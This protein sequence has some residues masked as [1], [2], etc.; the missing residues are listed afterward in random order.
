MRRPTRLL[1]PLA[2]A[3]GALGLVACEPTDLPT[4]DRPDD[5]VVLTGAEV[6]DLVGIA[7]DRLVAFKFVL[8]RWG[9]VPVQV[10]ER[11]ALDFAAPRN[12]AP[13]GRTTLFYTD[14]DTWTG[15]D[16]D[17][18]LDANDEV[19]FMARDAW[20]RARSFDEN[21]Y[22]YDLAEPP[23]VV[24][25]R[26]MEIRIHDPLA[27]GSASF[28]YL[29]ESAGGLDPTA[30]QSYVDYDFNL[31]SGDYTTTY[32]V[33][34][35]PN[36][37][38]S[39]VTTPAYSM[40]FA[41]R[42]I[43]DELRV[44]AGGASGVDVLDRHKS[45]FAGS[46][47][48]TETTFSQ[49]SG[50]IIASRSGPV[51]AVRSYLGANSGPVT[52]RD[53][54]LYSTRADTVTSLRVHAIPPLRDWFDYSAA[55][56]GMT[57]STNLDPGVTVDGQPESTATALV[58]WQM[59]SGPQ[60]SIVHTSEVD[61]NIAFGAGANQTFYRDDLTPPETQCTGDAVEYG[62]SGW[63]LSESIPCTDPL[64]NCTSFLTSTRRTTF[65]GPGATAA[66]AAKIAARDAAPLVATAA[67][68]TP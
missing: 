8:G 5:P 63:T 20:G 11:A 17:P 23:G 58:D 37:E 22:R 12:A 29:F 3:L 33:G 25:G 54:L 49:G 61:T 67:P 50:A 62:A 26:G 15:P 27:A 43:T 13:T 57:Y 4:V 21:G 9:Q 10:D 66:D 56:S 32:R 24:P 14:P 51:R 42:W 30:G 64:T 16:P 28:V 19:V 68:F 65:R 36:P 46:C 59:V 52:Q 41:D 39:R 18:T 31:L 7:P 6:A 44:T 55:A 38:D 53:H 40:R 60:G 45:G 34:A 48:R 35:G 1:A 2:L 47:V